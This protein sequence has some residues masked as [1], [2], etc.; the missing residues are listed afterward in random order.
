MEG[1]DQ[2]LVD[3]LIMLKVFRLQDFASGLQCGGEDQGVPLFSS[4]PARREPGCESLS[5]FQTLRCLHRREPTRGRDDGN[6][7]GD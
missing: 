7:A 2:A 5:I 4:Y 1:D 6:G 3:V